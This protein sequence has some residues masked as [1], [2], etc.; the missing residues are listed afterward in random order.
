M[1]KYMHRNSSFVVIFHSS[2]HVLALYLTEISLR[3]SGG[4]G[5]SVL[6]ICLL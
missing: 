1:S 3:E 2:Q 6:P 4:I 5:K